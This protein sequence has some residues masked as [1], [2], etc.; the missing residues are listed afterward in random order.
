MGHLSDLKM[1]SGAPGSA[2]RPASLAAMLLSEQIVET[3]ADL[4]HR[5]LMR[6]G[7]GIGIAGRAASLP[8][9]FR[10]RYAPSGYLDQQLGATRDPEGPKQ[11]GDVIFADCALLDAHPV[12]NSLVG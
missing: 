7:G 3:S 6:V 11:P 2:I 12:G 1:G 10:N 9:R 5:T 4:K 8:C